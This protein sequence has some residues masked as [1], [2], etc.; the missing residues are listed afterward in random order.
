MFQPQLDD[1]AGDVV[2]ALRRTFESVAG[3]LI[4]VPEYAGGMAG[5]VKNVL[6]WMVG[7]A[8]LYHRPVAVVSA[9][10]TGGP[11]A[12]EQTVRTLSW[13]GALV[14]DTLSIAA[15]RTKVDAHGRVVDQDT[16]DSIRRWATSLVGETRTQLGTLHPNHCIVAVTCGSSVERYRARSARVL[17]GCV[18][19]GP[20]RRAM[21]RRLEIIAAGGASHPGLS[22]G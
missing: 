14:V 15:A 11:F 5:G 1:D 13:Q 3:V 8:S 4:A 16:V 21:S 9:G 22:G 20:G 10:T 18:W 12:I 19:A 6:D 17:A 2:G 7:S